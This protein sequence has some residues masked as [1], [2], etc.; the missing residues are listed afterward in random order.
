MP[1]NRKNPGK[2]LFSFAINKTS[3]ISAVLF[4]ISPGKIRVCTTEKVY[5][6][7]D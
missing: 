6:E 7:K 5:D 3:S 2:L 4:Q 1:E